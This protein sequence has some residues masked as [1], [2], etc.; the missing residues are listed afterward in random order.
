MSFIVRLVGNMA[1]IWV[2]TL[3]VSKITIQSGT[4]VGETVLILAGIALVFTVVNS[5]ARPVISTVAFPLYIITFG[6][7]ALVTNALVFLLTG[8][9][10]SQLGM[11][12][13][14]GGFWPALAGGTITAII[15]AIV[16]SALGPDRR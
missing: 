3:L 7:F 12:F 6:L 2:S 13:Q 15:S 14:V 10:A 11:P 1:G 9:L 4:S 16:V 5:I 8:W